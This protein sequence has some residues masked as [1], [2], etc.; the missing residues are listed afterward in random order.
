LFAPQ[1]QSSC[2]RKGVRVGPS[3]DAQSH[4]RTQYNTRKHTM[5]KT[6]CATMED[7]L[8]HSETVY[9]HDTEPES[10]FV[11]EFRTIDPLSADCGYWVVDE[12]GKAYGFASVDGQGCIARLEDGFRGLGLSAYVIWQ[13]K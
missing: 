10:R 7:G 1:S 5:S 12:N 6:S 2:N 3:F 13:C 4:D 9:T 11:S 8:L